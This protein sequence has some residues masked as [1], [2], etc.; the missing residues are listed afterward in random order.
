MQSEN[1]WR[2]EYSYFLFL[3]KMHVKGRRRRDRRVKLY[4]YIR[5]RAD[6]LWRFS[7]VISVPF[8]RSDIVNYK[9]YRLET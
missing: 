6:V 8:E 5:D 1:S 3:M 2:N 9:S 7:P 4:V